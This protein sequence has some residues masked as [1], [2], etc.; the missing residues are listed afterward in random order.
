MTSKLPQ[1]K[2]RQVEKVLIKKVF[3][4]DLQNQVMLSLS[5]QTDEGQLYLF[6]IAL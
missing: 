3:S 2:P 1:I 6:I 5:T 4:Q